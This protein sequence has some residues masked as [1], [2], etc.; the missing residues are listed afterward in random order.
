MRLKSSNPPNILLIP[1]LD[2]EMIWQTHLL[3]PE[4]YE[5]D[6]LRL[7][8]RV[9]DHSLIINNITQT[10]KKEAFLDTCQLYQKKF[11]EEYCS[12][13]VK[14]KVASNFFSLNYNEWIYSYWDKTH[15]EFSSNS[16]ID[17]ENPFSFTESDFILDGKWLDLCKQFMYDTNK[18]LSIWT[19][20]FN[21]SREIDLGSEALKQLK[22]SYEKFLYIAAEYPRKY[23]NGFIPR[24]YA[25]N[26]FL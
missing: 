7:F 17:Y 10:F 12:L 23:R 20:F 25:V 3:R 18:K 14:N 24:T 6:C 1:T 15:F 19:R 21:Q 16:T 22:K 8:G 9:I 13:P 26:I 4:I 11:R 2:I 5:N